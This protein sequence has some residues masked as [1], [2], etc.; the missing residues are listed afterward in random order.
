MGVFE[1]ADYKS[2]VR[3]AKFK[4]AKVYKST[5]AT[6][7]FIHLQRM[8]EIYENVEVVKIAILTSSLQFT[9]PK[10]LIQRVLCKLFEKFNIRIT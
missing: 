4:K 6:G 9:T 3:I 5:R 8:S 2:D 1:V 7:Q 10:T